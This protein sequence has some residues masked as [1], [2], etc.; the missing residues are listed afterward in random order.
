M[1]K[2]TRRAARVSGTCSG[3]FTDLT[4]QRAMGYYDQGFLNYYYYMASQF[5]VSDRWFSP[6]SSKSIPNRIATFTGGTTQ[7]LVFDPRSND[8]LAQLDYSEL[9]SRNSIPPMCHGRSTTP[10]PMAYAWTTMTAAPAPRSILRRPS[11][12]LTYSFQYLQRKFDR[13]PRAPRH[14]AFERG[15]RCV[16]FLLHRSEPHRSAD[17]PT[18]PISPTAR[19]PASASLK[20]ATAITTSIP[21]RA[22]PF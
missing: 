9:S 8:H 22:S 2:A 18:S 16:E 12:Y 3:I 19:F 17:P 11:H 7:G 6:V 4:G 21:D 1:P 10:S 15:G 13:V 14:A 20:P 5:A